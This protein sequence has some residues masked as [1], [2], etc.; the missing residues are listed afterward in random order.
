VLHQAAL[1]ASHV[2]I[3]DAFLTPNFP[4]K[5]WHRAHEFFGYSCFSPF[6]IFSFFFLL[7]FSQATWKD[8]F[9]PGLSVICSPLIGR[10]SNT[11]EYLCCAFFRIK[12]SIWPFCMIVSCNW[13]IKN[14]IYHSNLQPHTV[15]AASYCCRRWTCTTK[16]YILFKDLCN[17]IWTAILGQLCL[18]DCHAVHPWSTQKCKILLPRHTKASSF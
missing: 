8:K 16:Q 14:M 15:L 5:V 10:N 11:M 4:F 2:C 7:C 17:A 12:H 18:S 3:V 9:G 6:S 1:R 13:I